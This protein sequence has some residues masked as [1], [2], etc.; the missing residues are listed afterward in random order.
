MLRWAELF[1]RSCSFLISDSEAAM[2]H[3]D[4]VLTIS[5]LVLHA[6]A[7]IVYNVQIARKQSNAPTITWLLSAF[8]STLNAFTYT[9]LSG[10]PY[11]SAFAWVS[12]AG[13][14]LTALHSVF[15]GEWLMEK[16]QII[17]ITLIVSGF[18]VWKFFADPFLG[19]V[20][21][22]SA[23]FFAIFPLIQVLRKDASLEKALPW[24]MWTLAL[25]FLAGV[26]IVRYQKW[27]DMLF[28]AF[29]AQIDAYIVYLCL[30]KASEEENKETEFRP[31]P[32]SE[33]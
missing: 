23:S 15:R 16:R 28:P 11:K 13:C 17:L 9:E 12:C 6:S 25:T 3:L 7:F 21:G 29:F 4:L 31:F 20:L 26:V 24:I 14:I 10:D 1:A 2:Q 19:Q 33:S 22:L 18:T 27:Q 8:L 30:R 32:A 5:A